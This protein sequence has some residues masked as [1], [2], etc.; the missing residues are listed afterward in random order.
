MAVAD[1]GVA[2]SKNDPGPAKPRRRL[3]LILTAGLVLVVLFVAATG[4][5]G[6]YFSGVLLDAD[7]SVSYPVEVKAVD[8]GQVT[9]SRNDDTERA[10]VEG[11]WWDGGEALLSNA[12]T[13][14]GESVV[15]TVTSILHGSLSAGLRATVDLRTFDGDPQTDRGLRFDPVT[16]AGEL[17]P[18]PA[19]FVPPTGAA[20]T[21]WV[22]AVHGR[23]GTL[24][25]P[26]RILPTLAAS[27]HPTLVIS[28]RNDPNAP[29]SPD[30][31][32]HLG[33]TEW[34]DVEAAIGYARAHGATGVVLYGWSMGGTLTVT[35]LRRMGAAD[36]AFVHAAVLDSPAIDWTTVLNYQGEQRSLPGFVIWTAER[37]I[38]LRGDLSLSGLDGRPYAPKLTVPTL[39][40]LDSSDRT[41]PN[42]PTLDFVAATPPGLVTLVKTTGGDHTGSWNVDPAAYEAKVTG[43]LANVP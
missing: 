15:R 36:V 41:V 38:E 21:V 6:Y 17:G 42:G 29:R 23:R 16:I 24:V 37:L 19:W 2:Q 27:G 18:M 7:N 26:L 30:G 25:E 32:Y 34:R 33:D 13:I 40:F 20:S 8:G 4:G 39:V 10:A 3:R 43:F 31:Y 12:V 9:L 14:N 35:A 28:Y 5:I 22:I 11:L 1:G